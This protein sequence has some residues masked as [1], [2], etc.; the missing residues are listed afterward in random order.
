MTRFALCRGMDVSR[1]SAAWVP[2][3]SQSTNFLKA[4][5]CCI[6]YTLLHKQYWIILATATT[7][8]KCK[9]IFEGIAES[10]ADSYSRQNGTRHIQPKIHSAPVFREPEF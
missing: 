1:G 10:F 7:I 3:F 6:L 9:E 5:I 4:A 8:E 2:G